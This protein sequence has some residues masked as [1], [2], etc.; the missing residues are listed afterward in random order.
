MAR[1]VC[2]RE[3]QHSFITHTIFHILTTLKKHTHKPHAFYPISQTTSP[4]K[5]N[6]KKYHTQT[7]LLP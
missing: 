5:N 2:I 6:F 3:N 1:V 4:T 7:F